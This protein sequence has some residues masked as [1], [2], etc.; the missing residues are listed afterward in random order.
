MFYLDI[1]SDKTL[2]VD[3]LHKH[4]FSSMPDLLE[5]LCEPLPGSQD[6]FPRSSSLTALHSS[7]TINV[8]GE[9]LERMKKAHEEAMKA[10]TVSNQLSNHSTMIHAPSTPEGRHNTDER[11]STKGPEEL[12]QEHGSPSPQP[13][14]IDT[15]DDR[16][17]RQL[18]DRRQT[19]S[20]SLHASPSPQ[21]D[22]G[23]IS[24]AHTLDFTNAVMADSIT[25]RSM[26][27]SKV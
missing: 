19:M 2:D 25:P 13:S 16:A 10:E 22:T 5:D 7:T 11:R 4:K 18:G 3:P 23:S 6:V 27:S 17:A 12:G 21:P 8:N 15:P 9:T 14:M 24:P 20:P 26:D 1:I